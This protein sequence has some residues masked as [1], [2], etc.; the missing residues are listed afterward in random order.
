MGRGTRPGAVLWDFDGTMVDSEPVWAAVQNEMLAGFGL[1]WDEERMLSLVGESARF[2][3]EL[4]ASD[5]GRPDDVDHLLDVME[6]HVGERV[7]ADPPWLPGAQELLAE[8]AAHG[9]PNA[10]VT[11]SSARIMG[12]LAHHLPPGLEF[13]VTGD[14]VTRVKPDPEAYLLAMRRLDVP[15]AETLVLEDSVPG[16]AA[17]LA[18]GAVVYAVPA[19]VELEPHPRLRVSRTG[20]AHTTWDELVSF[21]RES[22]A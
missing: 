22:R 10:V 19:R 21:W 9:V 15:P 11:A 2:C 6:A 8:I 20:L 5:I 3:A 4:M 1:R 14:D 18:A 13:V 7:A 17:A 12:A 16:T